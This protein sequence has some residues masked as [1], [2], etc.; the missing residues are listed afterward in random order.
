M[1]LFGYPL[2]TTPFLDSV[3]GQFYSNYISTAPNTFES[4]PGTL[5]L[6]DSENTTTANNVVTLAKAA[7]MKT[8]WLS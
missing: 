1:S 3:N 8:H 6:S 4:L 7:G 5:A 2:Q